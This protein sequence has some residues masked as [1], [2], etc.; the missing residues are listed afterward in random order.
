M[1]DSLSFDLSTQDV[2]ELF[3]EAEDSLNF[4]LRAC[5]NT[6]KMEDS[7][8]FD[9]STQDVQELFGK[10]SNGRESGLLTPFVLP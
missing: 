7:L 10:K 3:R 9:L 6:D 8:S 5:Q 1:E 2:Q 4:E